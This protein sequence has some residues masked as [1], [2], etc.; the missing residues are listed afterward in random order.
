MMSLT[1]EK[2]KRNRYY[3]VPLR[4]RIVLE[5]KKSLIRIYFEAD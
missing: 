3:A 1:H 5:N 2:M 4:E